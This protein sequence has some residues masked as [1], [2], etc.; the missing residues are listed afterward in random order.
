MIKVD[1]FVPESRPFAQEELRRARLQTLDVG[2]HARPFFV[3]SPEDLVLRK[4]D[5]Y[6]A[7]GEASERQWSDVLGVLK[8]QKERLDQEYLA[9]WAAD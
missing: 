8:V 7:G 3:K 5:W 4:L 2:I 1:I 6:R 9:H